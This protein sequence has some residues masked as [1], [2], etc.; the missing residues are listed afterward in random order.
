M[1]KVSCE[2]CYYF[3]PGPSLLPKAVLDAFDCSNVSLGSA[4]L[5]FYELSHRH[6]VSRQRQAEVIDLFR[7][8]YA[9]PDDYEVFFMAGGARHQYEHIVSNFRDH[10]RFRLL[11]SGYWSRLFGSTVAKICPDKLMTD[12]FDLQSVTLDYDERQSCDE[13]LLTV[14]NE[15][16]DGVMLPQGVISHPGMVADVTS[17]L[18]FTKINIADYAMLY[19]ASGKALGVAG[20]TIVILRRSLLERTSSCLPP[21]QSYRS[22]VESK[23]LYATPPLVCVDMLWHMLGWVQSKGGVDALEHHQRTRSQQL[24]DLLDT[25]PLYDVVVPH[26]YRSTQNICFAI[27]A[28]HQQDFF[29]RAEAQGIHGLCGHSGVGGARVNLYHGV[30]DDAFDYLLSF[31]TSYGV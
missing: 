24:Y 8:L 12:R 4:S 11:E 27:S 22:C 2:N 13:L 18:G 25:H 31:L 29:Q 5:R 1:V 14:Q 17:S 9:V 16:A 30:T 21:L 28:S 3:G 19:A 6:P 15:T 23:S 10:F 26:R 7:S 20:M